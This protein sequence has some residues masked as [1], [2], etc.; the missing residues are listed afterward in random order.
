MSVRAPKRGRPLASVPVADVIS[1][2]RELGTLDSLM[3]KLGSERSETVT[4]YLREDGRVSVRLVWRNRKTGTSVT[5]AAV[6][7]P[8]WLA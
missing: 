7:D 3:R 2:D 8:I 4:P 6:Y 5:H 1:H